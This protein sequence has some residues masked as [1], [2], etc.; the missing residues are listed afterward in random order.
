MAVTIGMLVAS[1]MCIMLYTMLYGDQPISR[2]AEHVY[3]GATAGY[4]AYINMRFY[5]DKGVIQMMEPGKI[6][7]IIPVILGA[8]IYTRLYA[9]TRWMYRYPMALLMGAM[10]GVSMRTTVF[11]QII[12]QFIVGNL[13]PNAP[14]L[15]VPM[16]VTIN[17]LIIIIGSLCATV[18]FIFS[19]DFAGPTRYIHRIGRL[20]LLCSFGATYGNTTSYRYELMAGTF[21]SNMLQPSDLLP[22][23][24]G[25]MAV[26]IIALVAIFKMGISSWD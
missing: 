25:F 11:S 16:G 22:Y 23:T 12:D 18:F 3:M 10:L 4:Y 20:F 8:M 24:L 21:I 13:P 1:W 17:N 2:F 14:L 6:L 26:V 7:Y 15:G 19:H 9:P 5:W